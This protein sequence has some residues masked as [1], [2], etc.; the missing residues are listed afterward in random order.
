MARIMEDDVKQAILSNRHLL[1]GLGDLGDTK[2][3]FE[4]GMNYG[5]LIADAIAFTQKQ[6]IIG[7]EIKTEY[8]TLKRLPKQLDSYVRVCNYVIVFC[9]D[10]KLEE[11][12]KLLASKNYPFVG[13]ISY[14]EFN[15][16]IITGMYRAPQINPLFKMK[17]CLSML[18]KNEI[19]AILS[20]YVNHPSNVVKN[21]YNEKATNVHTA[22]LSR[23]SQYGV[24]RRDMTKRAMISLYD[25]LIPEN[26]GIRII[27]E[28]FITEK[29][30]PNK[31]LQLYNYGDQFTHD[32]TFKDGYNK[33]NRRRH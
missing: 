6:G 28:M 9:H 33:H 23:N 19:Y 22:M 13:I 11:V 12:E 17:A 24:L 10:S 31:N 32:V 29:F 20:A 1:S 8:D 26:E 21:T 2:V 25:N 30:D 7:Y 4:K 18:W 14:S 15:D 27:C 16:D 5:N 3:I